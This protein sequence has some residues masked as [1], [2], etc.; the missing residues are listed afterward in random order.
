MIY[1]DFKNAIGDNLIDVKQY[2][3]EMSADN[4]DLLWDVLI[5]EKGI[6]VQE[7]HSYWYEGA[8]ISCTIEINPNMPNELIELMKLHSITL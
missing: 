3:I 2:Y 1:E 8:D 7:V 5:F 6:I 4:Q